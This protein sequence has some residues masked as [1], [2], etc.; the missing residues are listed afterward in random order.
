[1]LTTDTDP[2]RNRKSF[3]ESFHLDVA[4]ADKNDRT[5]PLVAS[6]SS[7]FSSY[8]AIADEQ[9]QQQHNKDDPTH[10]AVL[11][12]KKATCARSC[13]RLPA[14]IATL[15]IELIVAFVIA[16]YASTDIF[17]R[18]PLLL[19]FQPVVSALSGNIGLQSSSI[20]TREL[21]LGL[22]RFDRVHGNFCASLRKELKSSFLLS[23][24][25]ALMLGTISFLWYAPLWC[26]L[27]D[28]NGCDIVHQ[29][30]TMRGAA[31]FGCAVLIG[32]LLSGMLSSVAGS[33]A[34]VLFSWFGVDPTSAAGPMETAIQDVVGGTLLLAFSAFILENFG[35]F[36]VGCPGHDM[37]GC[38]DGCA[39]VEMGNPNSFNATC[40]NWCVELD[41]LGVC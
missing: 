17:R 2:R 38:V 39:L 10:A 37:R 29:N 23:V 27:F 40:L 11:L 3:R 18:Y 25:V 4:A 1:M 33:T 6:S 34:P 31:V 12:R 7:S 19:S 8:V 13:G 24:F 5:N 30:H 35:D 14:L 28:D 15:G 16:Q 22:L 36:G 9:Q 20:H 26:Q 21:A 41:A 32:Q